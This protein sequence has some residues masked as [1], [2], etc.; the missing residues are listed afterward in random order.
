M[1]NLG[2]S[3][4][5]WLAGQAYIFCCCTHFFAGTYR[6]ESKQ[7]T[8]T[9]TIPTVGPL[10]L[11]TKYPLKFQSSCSPFTGGKMSQI[12]AHIS[13]PVVFGPEYFW[14]A[15]LYWKTKTNLSR[16]DDRSSPHQ[17]WGG[18][19]PQLPEPWRNG[20]KSE[21]LLSHYCKR[22]LRSGTNI[23]QG[24]PLVYS[25][26]RGRYLLLCCLII[27]FRCVLKCPHPKNPMFFPG[28]CYTKIA[29]CSD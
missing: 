25:F 1:V 3:V 10:A 29:C 24:A 27:R 5:H 15:A 23:R 19:V 20:C 7:Q 17:T 13:T 21:K 11:L 9:D 12:L 6:W 22:L 26:T 4:Q 14:T 16:I 18:S 8:P 28:S 2:L